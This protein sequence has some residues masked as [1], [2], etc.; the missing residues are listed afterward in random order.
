MAAPGRSAAMQLSMFTRHP[1]A[2][3]P[4]HAR[5]VQTPTL[6]ALSSKASLSQG[7][8]HNCSAPLGRAPPA[9]GWPGRHKRSSQLRLHP[10]ALPSPPARSLSSSYPPVSP[11]PPPAH[12]LQT[13]PA[14]APRS[15]RPPAVGQHPGAAHQTP[16]PAGV[17][18]VHG[19]MG[20][21]LS[22]GFVSD[23]CVQTIT[24]PGEPLELCR[25][26]P[27]PQAC[28]AAAQKRRCSGYEA[29]NTI[30]SQLRAP[31]CARTPSGS[32]SACLEGQAPCPAQPP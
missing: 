15:T 19:G 24:S 16:V 2:T 5:P 23:I 29:Q 3:L 9:A 26:R 6:L 7:E 25:E 28:P 10:P 8:A 21:R 30:T 27:C 17:G 4:G 14:A 20:R 18:R 22:C 1:N 32:Y 13:P 12:A 11:H 31:F